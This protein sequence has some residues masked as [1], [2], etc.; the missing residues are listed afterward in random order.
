M[1]YNQVDLLS[2]SK[3]I[4]DSAASESAFHLQPFEIDSLENFTGKGLRFAGTFESAGIF[5][6]FDDTLRL[7]KDYSLGFKRQTPKDG[8][9]IDFEIPVREKVQESIAMFT[10]NSKV[11]FNLRRRMISLIRT[12]IDE[13]EQISRFES[14]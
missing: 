11:P 14:D 10:R 4:L 12:F 7:Q 6:I 1:E 3:L 13:V 2:L 8:F 5:P 9:D